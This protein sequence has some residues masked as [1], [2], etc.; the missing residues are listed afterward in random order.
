MLTGPSVLEDYQTLAAWFSMC[1][2]RRYTLIED[3]DEILTQYISHSRTIHSDVFMIQVDHI[4]VGTISFII[5]DNV[6]IIHCEIY[7]YKA[8]SCHLMD[9][10]IRMIKQYLVKTYTLKKLLF[11]VF[12][13][14]HYIIDALNRSEFVEKQ[15]EPIIIPTLTGFLTEV[16]YE[17][18]L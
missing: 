15:Q 1:A 18:V 16:S 7:E 5:I 8:I 12:E 14:N 17:Y 2:F 3:Y 11:N 10:L 6:A 9:E 4:N 13:Y